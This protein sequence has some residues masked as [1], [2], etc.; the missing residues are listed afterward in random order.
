MNNELLA[1]L[2]V[3]STRDEAGRHFTKSC[4][5][6][7]ELEEEGL[8]AVYRPVHEYTGIAY[9]QEEWTCE[10]T[11]QGIEALED[12]E[13]VAFIVVI[14]DLLTE[15]EWDKPLV[16]FTVTT[17]KGTATLSEWLSDNRTTS[18]TLGVSQERTDSHIRTCEDMSR[19]NEIAGD[20]DLSD[21]LL[22]VDRLM[23]MDARIVDYALVRDGGV[24]TLSEGVWLYTQDAIQEE[25]TGWDEN[26]QSKNLDLTQYPYWITTDSGEGPFGFVSIRDALEWFN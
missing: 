7:Q 18:N 14:D 8:I 13:D 1:A 20:F 4:P 15:P 25:Q 12:L 24:V 10:I 23:G 5:L 2:A 22:A 19:F 3:I 9:G 21:V 17:P 16:K 6:W 26:D 11:E